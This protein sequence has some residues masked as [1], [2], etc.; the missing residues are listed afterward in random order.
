M[1]TFYVIKEK[2]AY[3]AGFVDGEGSINA[4][5]VKRSDY[6]LGFQI[7]VSISSFQK[8][9]RYHFL[10]RLQKEIGLGAC[11]KRN[12]G[13]AEY[14]I[15]GKQSVE[16]ILPILLPYLRIKRK[17]AILVLDIC[18]KLSK[19]QS[20]EDFIETCLLVDKIAALN[21]SKKRKITME[22]VRNQQNNNNS[23]S[24]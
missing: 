3:I 18:K 1:K 6:R 24:P 15:V 8:V 9:E 4:Q 7:R 23:P 21:D 22:I 5:I 16:K 20:Q 11:R 17:Q 10:L 2:A 14:A 19:E 13:M 12:D